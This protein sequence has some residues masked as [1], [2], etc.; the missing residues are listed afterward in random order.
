MIRLPFSLF[1]HEDIDDLRR[2]F[3]P[4]TVLRKERAL[5][6][7]QWKRLQ[8][9]KTALAMEV[10]DSTNE[11]AYRRR[12][13]A[14]VQAIDADTNTRRFKTNRKGTEGCCG[15]GCNGC[16]IFWQDDM[17]AHARDVLRQRKQGAMLSKAE[18][19]DLKLPAA[20]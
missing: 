8:L 14:L 6:E 13:D 15:K 12:R 4:F 11:T 10:K 19:A 7:E 1:E 3:P 18:A 16:M 5:S 20:Q 2:N 17:Y 9:D